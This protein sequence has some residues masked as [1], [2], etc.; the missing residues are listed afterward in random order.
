MSSLCLQAQCPVGT[1]RTQP[2]Y[3]YFWAWGRKRNFSDPLCP[4]FPPLQVVKLKQIEHTL[5]E[6]RI[7]QA[8]NFP[9]LVKLEFSFKVGSRG[10]E[11][12]LSGTAL[13]LPELGW[14]PRARQ[15]L[16]EKEGESQRR[17]AGGRSPP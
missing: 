3:P 14:G 13:G 6:K 11:P 9:F 12:L 7:L 8:V 1:Q 5:N 17:A 4:P 2:R 15:A 10:P 16:K